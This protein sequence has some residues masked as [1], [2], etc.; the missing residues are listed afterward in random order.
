MQRFLITFILDK[1]KEKQ[2]SGAL[3]LIDI[4]N[5]KSQDAIKHLGFS[6]CLA[7]S[8]SRRGYAPTTIGAVELNFCVRHV[9]RC[10]LSAIATRLRL[11][12][13]ILYTFFEKYARIVCTFKTNED[14]FQTDCL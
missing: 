14:P 9:N 3:S 12:Q 1:H 11:R 10:D 13:N 5:T 2:N 4:R 6:S 8:Y 7:A